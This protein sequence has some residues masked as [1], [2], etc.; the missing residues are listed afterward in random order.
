MSSRGDVPNLIAVDFYERGDV[1]PRHELNRQGARRVSERR[2][3]RIR[4]AVIVTTG[5]IDGGGAYLGV[6]SRTTP[7]TSAQASWGRLTPAA[8]LLSRG[9][10]S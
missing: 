3:R 10:G 2:R 8:Q 7:R 5:Q 1:I 4:V 6:A 9:P